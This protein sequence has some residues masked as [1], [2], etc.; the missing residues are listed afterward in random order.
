MYKLEEKV[1]IESQSSNLNSEN[2]TMLKYDD[3]L[4]DVEKVIS[5]DFCVMKA[6]EPLINALT[7]LMLQNINYII[8]VDQDNKFLGFVNDTLILCKFPPP[9][10]SLPPEYKIN[11]RNFHKKVRNY[12]N[13]AKKQ[14]IEDILGVMPFFRCFYKN[15]ATILGAM[16]EL[17][18]PYG[19]YIEEKIIP[20]LNENQNLVGV[21]S[22]KDILKFIRDEPLLINTSV[23]VAFKKKFIDLFTLP[24]E[25]TLASAYLCIEYIPRE[26]ILICDERDNLLGW[27]NRRKVTPMAHPLYHHLIKMP[28]KEIMEP[29][30]KLDL[31]ESKQA[32]SEVIKAFLDKGREAVVIVTKNKE[33]HEIPLGIIT[34]KDVLQFFYFNFQ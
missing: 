20:V 8:V 32:I 30:T 6:S 28:I 11:D 26:Y 14:P 9:D 3:L 15:R 31:I 27:I 12:I 34:P 33:N 17:V 13:H 2:K 18:K 19:H 16:E 10:S 4:E 24:P 23:E 1:S 21:V 7:F 25:T 5:Y 22:D 29:V